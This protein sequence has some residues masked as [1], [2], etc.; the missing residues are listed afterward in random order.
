LGDYS[1]FG[2]EQRGEIRFAYE[3]ESMNTR[4]TR[5]S[6]VRLSFLAAI[7]MFTLAAPASA[8]LINMSTPV[9]NPGTGS[10]YAYVTA[11]HGGITWNQAFTQSAGIKHL[12]LDG[13]MVVITSAAENQ[14]L[15]DNLAQAVI[16][17][18]WLGGFQVPGS[19][20]PADG[21]SWVT[22]EA[23][24]SYNNWE[25]T[26]PEPNNGDNRGE[27]EDKLAFWRVN[28]EDPYVPGQVIGWWNDEPNWYFGRG[29][30]MEFPVPAPATVGLLGAGMV[31]ASR[32]RR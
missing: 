20:E 32:R 12:G 25:P 28:Y 27:G 18:Y 31:L 9:F 22:G 15:I 11:G 26:Q 30:I 19:P 4:S 5:L 7:S 3:G 10:Y 14:F 8:G 1:D 24:S 23:F 6:G 17:M 13:H 29:Y 21:W 16:D 2:K